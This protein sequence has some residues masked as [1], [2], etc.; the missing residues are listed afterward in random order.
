MSTPELQKEVVAFMPDIVGVTSTTVSYLAAQHVLRAIKEL[1]INPIMA[2]EKGVVALDTRIVV[3][4]N[5]T[6]LKPYDHMAIHPYPTHLQSSWH[7]NDGTEI[8]IRPIRP[9]DAE[10][11][12]AFIRDLSPKAKYFR[13]MQA[14]REL[15]PQMLIRFTQIDYDREMA[16][17]A[18]LDHE[19]K[20]L[21]VGVTRYT[22]NP[23][24]ES[25]EFALV[26][27]DEWQ[28]KGIGSRLMTTLMATA[29]NRGFKTMEGEILADNS[30]M[31][32][33]VEH[34]G[35][36]KSLSTEDPHIVTAVKL[37]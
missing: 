14:L 28:H 36:T 10:I 13:F 37:L 25:C 34:L 29:K 5:Y 35:F 2:D 3:D 4:N 16:F 20:E 19:G 12:D 8:T 31:L 27:D 30:E 9:E 1:D 7:I 18:V 17:I 15:T 23:D 24:G 6:Q 26:V 11:E 22:T 21:E 33:L 32:K